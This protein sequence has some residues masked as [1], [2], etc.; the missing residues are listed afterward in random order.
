MRT[1]LVAL[2]CLAIMA[3]GGQEAA[4]PAPVPTSTAEPIPTEAPTVA[5]TPTR[6]AAPQSTAEPIP[7]EAPTVAPIPTRVAAPQSTPSSG[8]LE[9]VGAIAAEWAA[10]NTEAVAGLVVEAVL[11]SPDVEEQVPTL[12]RVSF[13]GLLKTAVADEL[14]NSLGVEVESVAFH[15]DSTYSAT[16][17]V[18]GTVAVEIGPVA[19]I[20]VAVPIVVTVDLDSERATAWE[21][22]KEQ[23]EVTVR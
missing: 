14:G 8:S 15:G 2:A 9:R 13:G 23:A 6:V 17:A 11:A 18:S 4:P 20:D 3:C 7:T 21:A 22:D 10:K 16:L 5:P 1:T 12:L 19:A